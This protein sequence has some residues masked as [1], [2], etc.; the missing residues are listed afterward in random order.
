MRR[1]AFGLVIIVALLTA[2]SGSYSDDEAFRVINKTL[3]ASAPDLTRIPSKVEL[4]TSPYIKGKVAVFQSLE[5]LKD[6][7]GGNKYFMQPS[8]YREMKESYAATPGEVGTVAL[9]NCKVL[10]KGIYKSDDGKEYP[11]KVED[12]ELTMIDRSKTAV[13]FKKLFEKTPSEDRKVYTDSVMTQTSQGEV[14]QF[15]KGLPRT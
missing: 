2:C 8:Y 10:Q 14:L 7:N 6:A 9:L 3:M 11:A 15:L 5:H 1:S 12:C 13:V 4:A